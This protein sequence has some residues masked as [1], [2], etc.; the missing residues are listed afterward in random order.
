MPKVTLSDLQA[1][2]TGHL[3][4]VEADHMELVVIR[5]GHEPMVIV[6]LAE[7]KSLRETA[8]LL[9]SPANAAHLRRSIAEL[10]R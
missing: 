7:L 9:S 4:R 3:D 6:P 5:P 10:D 1:D 8:Y 2:I